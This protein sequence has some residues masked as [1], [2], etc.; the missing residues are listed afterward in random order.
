MQSELHSAIFFWVYLFTSSLPAEIIQVVQ[1]FVFGCTVW[2]KK[3]FW[4]FI[5]SYAY[6]ESMSGCR[7]DFDFGSWHFTFLYF[8]L[9]LWYC[10]WTVSWMM[11]GCLPPT[12]FLHECYTW[13]VSKTLLVVLHASTAIFL[14]CIKCVYVHRSHRN[15]F[16]CCLSLQCV[17]YVVV[18][19]S[20]LILKRLN[21]F[22][23]SWSWPRV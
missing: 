15:A 13:L 5:A 8:T 7:G 11:V 16:I 2:R 18:L 21:I 23:K 6:E 9:R 10:L 4:N 3:G 1:C 22:S 19:F 14:Q 17:G 12:L 20:R